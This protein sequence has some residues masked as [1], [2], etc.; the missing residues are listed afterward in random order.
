MIQSE[1]FFA[2]ELRKIEFIL[3][4]GPEFDP[5][6]IGPQFGGSQNIEETGEGFGINLINVLYGR[7]GPFD[8][9]GHFARKVIR[10]RQ[11][12]GV[13]YLPLA[14]FIVV[15]GGDPTTGGSASVLFEHIGAIVLR[16]QIKQAVTDVRD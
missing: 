8:S 12:V 2:T 9:V 6:G 3:V 5:F 1:W 10:P 4:D 14:D 7:Q 16:G 13:G 11:K 15:G